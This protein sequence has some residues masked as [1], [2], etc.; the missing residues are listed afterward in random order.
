MASRFVMKLLGN[1]SPFY[2]LEE[3]NGVFEAKGF[4]TRVKC[5]FFWCYVMD[6]EMFRGG[7]NGCCQSQESQEQ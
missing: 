2:L 1:F 3:S 5:F 7:V 4:V 6:L